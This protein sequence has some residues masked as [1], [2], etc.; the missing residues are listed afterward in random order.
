MNAELENYQDQLLSITQGA[1]GIV[2]GLSPTQF[3]RRP[4]PDRWSVAESLDHLNLTARRFLPFFDQSIDAAAARGLTASGPFAYPL[5]ERLFLVAMEPPPR[6]RV[7]A[8]SAFIPARNRAVDDVLR[9]FTDWQDRLGER[10]R[11]ADGLDLRRA[12]LRSPFVPWVRY[13]LGI[14][15]AVILAHERRHL[16]Q[17]RQ[18]RN[19]LDRA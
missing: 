8:P 18:V 14:G 4:A 11:R 5:L 13:S 2:R 7:R 16:W 10:I 9:E 12:R 15:F 3:N 17:A 19:E 6:V 1:P